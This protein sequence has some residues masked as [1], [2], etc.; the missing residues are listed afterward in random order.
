MNSI[1]WTKSGRRS[2]LKN[3]KIRAGIAR[4]SS[5]AYTFCVDVTQCVLRRPTAKPL[6]KNLAQARFFVFRTQQTK[7]DLRRIFAQMKIFPLSC[8]KSCVCINS[9]NRFQTQV[10]NDSIHVHLDPTSNCATSRSGRRACGGGRRQCAVGTGSTHESK[11]PP[12]QTGRGF[13]FRTL[14]GKSAQK[15]RTGAW[16]VR[17]QHPPKRV[18]RARS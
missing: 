6:K 13:S 8:P 18:S 17:A 2:I 9:I 3:V 1:L 15:K 14:P 16:Q 5:I 7:R 11:T 4:S 12:A 10:P